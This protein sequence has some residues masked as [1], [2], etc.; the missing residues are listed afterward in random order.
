MNYLVTDNDPAGI[1][2]LISGDA[3]ILA[4]DEETEISSV[5]VGGYFGDISVLYKTPV[6]ATVIAVT[7]YKT[8]CTHYRPIISNKRCCNGQ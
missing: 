8:N 7:R 6:I 1:L 4:A 3:A 5:P 2:F